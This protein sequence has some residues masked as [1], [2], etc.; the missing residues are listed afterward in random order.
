MLPP[1]IWACLTAARPA[2]RGVA[3][4]RRSRPQVPLLVAMSPKEAGFAAPGSASADGRVAARV[5]TSVRT[6]VW[7]ASKVY[8]RAATV[9]S[10]VSRL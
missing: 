8:V 4:T 5:P 9:T 3:E 6:V 2:E 1:T 7:R 10:S